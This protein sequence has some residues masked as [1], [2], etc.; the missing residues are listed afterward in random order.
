MPYILVVSKADAALQDERTDP[1]G[2][3]S[4]LPSDNCLSW[5][6]TEALSLSGN[7][8]ETHISLA[9][10]SHKRDSIIVAMETKLFTIEASTMSSEPGIGSLATAQN[11]TDF[12]F[13]SS[14]HA[15]KVSHDDRGIVL[16]IDDTR[17]VHYLEFAAPIENQRLFDLSLSADDMAFRAFE[18]DPDSLIYLSNESNVFARGPLQSQ[19]FD[20]SVVYKY[21]AELKERFGPYAQGVLDTVT[22][23]S[24]I[25]WQLGLYKLLSELAI[26]TNGNYRPVVSVNEDDGAFEL[27]ARISQDIELFLEVSWEGELEVVLHDKTHGTEEVAVKTLEQV[28]NRVQ[29][30]IK[31]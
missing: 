19:W 30:A 17:G 8:H 23:F 20:E 25:G 12:M 26:A 13:A 3:G 9:E 2:T 11:D 10:V 22:D 15:T 5:G 29:K 24:L 6:Q 18:D 28:L 27:E 1:K 31:Q 16:E 4:L 7:I 21:A 14:V